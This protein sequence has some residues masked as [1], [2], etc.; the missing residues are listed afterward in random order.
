MTG[1][2]LKYTLYPNDIRDIVWRKWGRNFLN[3][4]SHFIFEYGIMSYLPNDKLLDEGDRIYDKWMTSSN[5]ILEADTGY[6]QD[7]ANDMNRLINGEDIEV[8]GYS[9]LIREDFL[10]WY[11]ENK[12]T[13]IPK[14]EKDILIRVIATRKYF[15]GFQYLSRI[16]GDEVGAGF[17]LPKP[18]AIDTDPIDETIDIVKV[19]NVHKFRNNYTP[20]SARGYLEPK[21]G[22]VYE[23]MVGTGFYNIL[24]ANRPVPLFCTMRDASDGWMYLLPSY[25][26]DRSYMDYTMDYRSIEDVLTRDE[27]KGLTWATSDGRGV[28]FYNMPFNTTSF[29]FSLDNTVDGAMIEVFTG[30][31][32]Q[33]LKVEAKNGKVY[34]YISGGPTQV[35]PDG[36]ENVYIEAVGGT[37]EMNNLV[38]KITSSINGD[39]ENKPFVD[40]VRVK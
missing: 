33:V 13:D 12:K 19:D 22:Y 37:G 39:I 21:Q 18:S 6:Q 17:I 26:V 8:A 10:T 23:G 20:N 24:V 35:Y 15:K 7:I 1:D 5:H 25:R 32:G 30:S 31:S 27:S 38:I 3:E 40:K 28:Q 29:E 11:K 36:A 16:M 14:N 9:E 4:Y 34:S 2:N